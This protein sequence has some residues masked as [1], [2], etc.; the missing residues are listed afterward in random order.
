MQREFNFRLKRMSC[1]P[2]SAIDFAAAGSG[3][4]VIFTVCT[5]AKDN[6]CNHVGVQGYP[7][8]EQGDPNA[9]KECKGGRDLEALQAHAASMRAAAEAACSFTTTPRAWAGR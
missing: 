7:T 9:L 8:L 2:S 3:R 5:A 6:L 1:A 4:G